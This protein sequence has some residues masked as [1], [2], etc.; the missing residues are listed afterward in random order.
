VSH[1]L[2]QIRVSLKWRVGWGRH[3]SDVKLMGWERALTRIRTHRNKSIKITLGMSS[4]SIT[5]KVSSLI[6]T[7]HEQK[8]LVFV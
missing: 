1:T 3:D 5:A 6:K 4:V 7:F 2:P 8:S